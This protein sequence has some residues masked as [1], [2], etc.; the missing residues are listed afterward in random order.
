[1]I[2]VI[3]REMIIPREEFN[4]GTNYDANSEVRHFRI[5]RVPGGIDISQLTFNLDME[6]A[7]GK[8]DSVSLVK[9]VT[10]KWINL[11]L[12]VFNSML[13]VPGSVQIQLRALD[14]DGAVKWTSFKGA[15]YV[16]DS[17]DTPANY[18]EQLTEIENI[19]TAEN[20]RAEAEKARVAAESARAAAETARVAAE[21]ARESTKATR[22]QAEKARNDAEAARKEAEKARVQAE[23]TRVSAE[24]ERKKA[25]AARV[26]AEASRVKAEQARVQAEQNRE[27]QTVDSI[28][29]Y[30]T[31]NGT[32]DRGAGKYYSR[33][34]V[35]V[36]GGSGGDSG[37]G[38]S[39]DV[40][41]KS[42]NI[43]A[44]GIYNAADDDANGYDVVTVN[45]PTG[46]N[47]YS[48]LNIAIKKAAELGYKI[49]FAKQLVNES[50]YYVAD[51]LEL[52]E[53]GC[54][55]IKD[56]NFNAGIISNVYSSDLL[57]GMFFDISK[58][59]ADTMSALENKNMFCQYGIVKS[60][61][62]TMQQIIGSGYG[63]TNYTN[64]Y[65]KI[66]GE[67][68]QNLNYK[69]ILRNKDA[70]TNECDVYD[71]ALV[72]TESKYLSPYIFNGFTGY[73]ADSISKYLRI[74]FIALKCNEKKKFDLSSISLFQSLF[75][76]SVNIKYGQD[77][78]T[79]HIKG[80]GQSGYEGLSIDLGVAKMLFGGIECTVDVDDIK[81]MSSYSK[82]A[83]ITT[84]IPTNDFSYYSDIPIN[85]CGSVSFQNAVSQKQMLYAVQND[86]SHKYIGINA[87]GLLTDG[88]PYDISITLDFS[89]LYV[90]S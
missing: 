2:E 14:T 35:N 51:N 4:I 33:V 52:D 30:V 43:T 86:L 87:A 40:V 24:N 75:I 21:E 56:L 83:Y 80:T 74:P 59:T 18:K 37:G 48:F 22:E 36:K 76:D 25:E 73:G 20:E 19:K 78:I 72:T 13:Q 1:M 62:Y 61:G 23:E 69:E 64:W 41:L 89:N 32:Y 50:G 81:N 42:K 8:A 85:N 27:N 88:Q 12:T 11:T 39:E 38:S 15:F 34:R 28:P 45:V 6:Y 10:D 70:A 7:N 9:D 60:L 44:N 31:E 17:I 82:A 16:E 68:A 29:L 90:N 3:R 79:I 46:A 63:R 67:L 57:I 55:K 5:K 54:Y 47:T 49:V 58:Q 77:S 84:E 53:Y 66:N 26:E 71:C 65:Y